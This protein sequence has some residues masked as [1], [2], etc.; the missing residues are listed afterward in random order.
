VEKEG[1]MAKK[2]INFLLLLTSVLFLFEV[3]L[4]IS[5]MIETNTLIP[6]SVGILYVIYKASDDQFLGAPNFFLMPLM[7]LGLY[8]LFLKMTQS[9]E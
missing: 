6:D 8:T 3:G 7:I 2:L 1:I 5:Y 4:I 9:N